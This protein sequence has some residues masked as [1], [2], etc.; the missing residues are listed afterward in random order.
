MLSCHDCASNHFLHI[1]HF[2]GGEEIHRM[3]CEELFELRYHSRNTSGM[4]I[5]YFSSFFFIPCLNVHISAS[6]FIMGPECSRSQ[7]SSPVE[8]WEGKH[9][10]GLGTE[11]REMCVRTLRVSV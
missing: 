10:V 11:K 5:S 4:R 8:K 7:M 2:Y 1:V 3:L 6:S 9:G